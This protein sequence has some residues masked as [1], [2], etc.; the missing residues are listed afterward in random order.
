VVFNKPDNPDDVNIFYPVLYV[1]DADGCVGKSQAVA[2][3]LSI[4]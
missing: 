4:R 2:G 3:V 1:K